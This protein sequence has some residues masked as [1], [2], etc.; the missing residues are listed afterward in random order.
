MTSRAKWPQRLGEDVDALWEKRVLQL[1]NAGEV[2]ELARRGV[3]FQLH[4][5]RHRS[6]EDRD[7]YRRELQDNRVS[8]QGT[9]SI[10]PRHFCYPSGVYRHEFLP[11]LREE[12]VTSATTCEPGFA[13][14]GDDP[15]LL[16]RLVDHTGLSAVEFEGWLSGAASLLP[17]K[18]YNDPSGG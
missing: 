13:C 3:D 10:V 11:W 16:P 1:M 18:R 4:T 17:Q 8:I 2:A 9:T 5:H 15:L 6:P 12:N 14:A 7:L